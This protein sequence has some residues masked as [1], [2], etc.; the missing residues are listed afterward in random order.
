MAKTFPVVWLATQKLIVSVDAVVG[1]ELL[2]TTLAGK[3]MATV[4]PNFVLASHLQRLESFV[5]DIIGVNLGI[6]GLSLNKI[7]YIV[8]LGLQTFLSETT[9]KRLVN[10]GCVSVIPLC[11]H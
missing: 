6:K 11:N 1:V 7:C 10:I 8:L 9:V 3:H 5:T 2:A 4:L